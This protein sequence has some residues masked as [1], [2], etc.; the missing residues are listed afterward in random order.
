VPP[1]SEMTAK[2]EQ[3][4][5]QIHHVPSSSRRRVPRIRTWQM[6]WCHIAL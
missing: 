6:Q 1:S 3:T 5:H 2:P 4:R